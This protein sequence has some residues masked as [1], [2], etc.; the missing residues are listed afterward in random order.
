MKRK[1]SLGLFAAYAGFC[2]LTG[3]VSSSTGNQRLTNDNVAKITKGVTTRA[4]VVALLGEP[5]SVSLMS[6]GRRMM[7]YRAIQQNGDKSGTI[8]RAIVP[9][10]AFFPSSDT[11]TTRMQTLQ[12]YVGSNNVV[13]DY[14]YSDNTSEMKTTAS[15][16]GAHTEESTTPNDPAK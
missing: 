7:M 11:N 13:Q 1:G 4:E 10:A 3:C 14:E 6:D 9:F 8:V 5:E 15:A 2:F 16:F 12:I